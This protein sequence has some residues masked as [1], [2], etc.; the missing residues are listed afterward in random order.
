MKH[1]HPDHAGIAQVIKALSGAR[2]I[3]HQRQIPYFKDLITLFA[4]KGG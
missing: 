3:V 1:T 4:R 2:L